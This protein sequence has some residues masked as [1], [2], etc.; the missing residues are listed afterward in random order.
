MSS[1]LSRQ[2]ASE[3]Y[4]RIQLLPYLFMLNKGLLILSVKLLE[5]RGSLPEVRGPQ[6]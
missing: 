1:N 4:H 6:E 3:L 2:L 5:I